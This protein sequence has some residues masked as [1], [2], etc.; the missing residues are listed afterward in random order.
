[1]PGADGRAIAGVQRD[2]AL[3][4]FDPVD[5]GT[6]DYREI[7]FRFYFKNAANWTGGGGDKMARAISFA[8][9]DWSEAMIAHVWSGNSGTNLNHLLTEAASGTDEQGNLQT[10]GYNDFA[11]LRWIG[12]TPSATPV[13]DGSH[14]GQWYCVESR[15]RL[16]DAGQS[17]GA[18][19]L[20]IDGALEANTTGLNWVGAFDAYGINSVF[21]EN[22]WNSGSPQQQDRFFDNLVVSTQR[23]GCGS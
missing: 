15:V 22:F 3:R 23:I 16:N 9:S 12:S 18:F 10:N 7:Y 8:R 20:W 21:L 5:A 14:V 1:M 11:N 13:F 19:Q 4:G 2:A 17:N 6:S